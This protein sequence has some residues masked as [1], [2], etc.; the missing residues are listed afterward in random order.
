MNPEQRAAF[1]HAQAAC[2]MIEAMGMVADN[3]HRQMQ[4]HS[5]AYDG[6][7]FQ[8]LIGR[9]GIGHNDAVTWLHGQ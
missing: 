5:I 8:A 7:A 9:Y 4:G 3:Q 1:L 2:A 6:E